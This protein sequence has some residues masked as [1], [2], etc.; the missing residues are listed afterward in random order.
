MRG[1]NI[2]SLARFSGS[3]VGAASSWRVSLRFV[4]ASFDELLRRATNV[5]SSCRGSCSSTSCWSRVEIGDS[6]TEDRVEVAEEEVASPSKEGVQ[7]VS[8]AADSLSAREGEVERDCGSWTQGLPRRS[9]L[10]RLV[11]KSGDEDEVG[12]LLPLRSLVLLE[13]IC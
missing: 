6:R 1:R 12:D 5:S 4:P 2:C 11:F 8:V 13:N 7:G 10:S 9:R 3:T